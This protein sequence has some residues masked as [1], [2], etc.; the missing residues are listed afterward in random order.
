MMLSTSLALAQEEPIGTIT[1]RKVKDPDPRIAGKKGG[2]I[3]PAEMCNDL[4]IV[5]GMKN[6]RIIQ[7]KIVFN[8]ARE[9]FFDVAGNK[10]DGDICY[11]VQKS[12]QGDII[13]FEDILA[14][15]ELGRNFKLNPMRFEIEIV[16][17]KDVVDPT[18][19]NK[20]I[21][22]ADTTA[23][24]PENNN[25]TNPVKSSINCNGMYLLKEEYISMERTYIKLYNDSVAFIIKTVGEAVVISQFLERQYAKDAKNAHGKYY[26]RGET[27]I[28]EFDRNFSDFDFSGRWEPAGLIVQQRDPDGA[29][30]NG[31]LRFTLLPFSRP[32]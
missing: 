16:P 5:S 15:D 2:K 21:I 28:I 32:K 18:I 3:T 13:T 23:V 24:K 27:L 26:W 17:E 1:V 4:G 11:L 29:I 20:E 7:Y 6:V 30:I 9:R 10:I 25:V 22:K 8:S 12:K 31:E 19:E 14:Q